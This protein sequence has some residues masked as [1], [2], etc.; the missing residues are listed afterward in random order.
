[1]HMLCTSKTLR[2]DGNEDS[3]LRG[4]R[5]RRPPSIRRMQRLAILVLSSTLLSEAVATDFPIGESSIRIWYA[6]AVNG[7]DANDG[8]SWTTA[9]RTLQ[10][11]IDLSADGDEVLV[12]DGTYDP[13]VTDNK[14]IAIRSVNGAETTIIDGGWTQTCAVLSPDNV[15]NQWNTIL[16]GFTIQNGY[17]NG[18]GATAGVRFGTIRNCVVRNNE[19]H[20]Y[21]ASCG[22]YVSRAYNC[23]FYGNTFNYNGIW[24]GGVASWSYVYNCTIVGNGA[25]GVW[26]SHIYNTIVWGNADDIYISTGHPEEA[27]NYCCYSAALYD[28]EGSIKVDPM[29]VDA[30]N[31]DY[32]LKPD[33]PCIDAGSNNYAGGMDADCDGNAR[34]AGVRVDMGAYEYSPPEIGPPAPTL[35]KFH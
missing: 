14:A 28:G 16:V 35:V 4:V 34:I 32:R 13:I 31:R 2:L 33:S 10:A 19:G 22:L 15:A 12:A 3:S 24:G 7:N 11:A 17:C 26:D 18:N 6:D 5:R 25:Y 30:A 23:V 29:F 9:K 8:A 27:P 21:G 1:M 20:G